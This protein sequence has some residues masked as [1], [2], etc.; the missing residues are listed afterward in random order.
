[1]LASA[2]TLRPDASG[3]SKPLSTASVLALLSDRRVSTGRLRVPSAP[4]HQPITVETTSVSAKC[5]SLPASET[6]MRSAHWLNSGWFCVVP[7][8]S[9]SRAAIFPT[10]AAPATATPVAG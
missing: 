5:F 3:D 2:T 1:M 9:R 4:F 7:I 6:G 10:W 8:T